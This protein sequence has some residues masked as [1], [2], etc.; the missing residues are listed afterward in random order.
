MSRVALIGENSVEYVNALLDIWN[1][2][3]CAVLIDWRIP[4]QTAVE[5][6]QEAGVHT[7]YFEKK[8]LDKAFSAFVKDIS[9]LPY[10]RK[11]ASAECLPESFY[12]K[13]KQN[14]SKKEAIV[15]YSSGTTGRSKGIILSHFAINTNADAII[16]Y[17]KLTT[18]DCI[19]IAKTLSHSSTLTGELLVALKTHT[20]LVI[21]PTI[22][23]PR[24]IIGSISKFNVT[25]VCL[26]PILLSM[27]ADEIKRGNYDIISL[28]TIYVSGSVL[29]DNIYVKAH[30][31]FKDI[32]IYNVYGLSEAGPRVSAQRSDCC[33]SNSVGRELI[34]VDIIV[35]DGKGNPVPIEERGIVHINTP[36]CYDGYI[37]GNEKCKSLYLGWLNTGDVGFFDIN[38]ELH[39]VDRTDDVIIIDSHKI[40]PQSIVNDILQINGILD[41]AVFPIETTCNK[42]RTTIICFY[43]SGSMNNLSET[44]RRTLLETHPKYEVPDEFICVSNIERNSSGKILKSKLIE[45]YLFLKRSELVKF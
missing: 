21:A 17:M 20:K 38:G 3:D 39:I 30:Q 10:E 8:L 24:Y 36:S 18:T 7:C 9:F 22:V 31:I 25:I 33:K 43:L 19:Y 29:N 5:M 11:T 44:I 2:G 41:C 14:Y 23:P 6:M 15:L 16:D 13:F 26:N 40:Y 32:A 34:N 45:H 37:S 27:F 28:R 35:V 4:F 12:V 42:E 1:S